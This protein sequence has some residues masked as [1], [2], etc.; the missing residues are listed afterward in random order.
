M[1]ILAIDPG[2]TIGFVLLDDGQLAEHWEW[3]GRLPAKDDPDFWPIF[4]TVFVSV[5]S[6][7]E[8]QAV[9]IEDYRI[10]A[11]K[12]NMHI[13]NRLFT[14]E[15]IG[16]ISALCAAVAPP[17]SI[18]RLPASKKGRWPNARLD[19]KFPQHR[20]VVGDHERDALKLA[21]AYKEMQE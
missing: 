17:V 2:E 6:G 10:Y 12:A 19:A 14:A 5:L 9:V 20:A 1:K 16:A 8:P 11:D 15:L 18:H 7:S 4:V 3:G 13:G 21:L